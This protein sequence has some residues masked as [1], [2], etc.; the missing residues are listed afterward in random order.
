[1]NMTVPATT[2]DPVA[3]I[4]AIFQRARQQQLPLGE[5][6][7]TAERLAS[8]GA[9]APALDLYKTWIAFNDKNPL[10]HVASFN[11][12]VLL[13]QTGDTAGALQAL[14]ATI[15]YKA[16]FAPAHIN[17]GRVY[18][19]C[20][21]IG[22]AVQQ[23]RDFAST[24]NEITADRLSYRL[25]ALK[26]MGRVLESAGLLEEAEAV[27]WLAIE[28]DPSK[29]DAAQHWLAAR[30]HQCKWPIF[31]SSEH[32]TRRQLTDAM[33]PM[34]IAC[35]KDDPLFQLGKAY[36]YNKKLVGRPDTSGF[37][38]KPVRNKVE[39]GQ[40]IRIGYLSSDLREHAVGF[41]LCEVL[42]L[43]HKENVEVY[44]YYCGTPRTNDKT[45]DRI[46][47]V[48]DGWRDIN[49]MSDAEAAAKIVEDEIDIL[50]DVNGY[51]KQARAGVFAYKPAPV[52]VNFCGYPGTLASPHHQYI[53]TDDYIVPPE[54]ELYYTEKVLRIACEQPV[55]RK[56]E[57]APKPTRAEYGLPEDAFIYACFNG[58]QKIT[59]ECYL[60]WMKILAATPG[61]ILW[62]LGDKEPV[63]QRLRKIASENGVDPERLYFANKVPN[64]KHLARIAL[65]D[66]F[67]D[68]FPYGA[69]STAAD[70]ITMGLPVI[71][72]P[73]MGFPSRFCASIVAAAGI[74][75]M[76][77]SSPEEY[78]AKATALGRDKK[79]IEAVKATLAA[80]RETCTLRDMPGLARRLEE[81]FREMQEAAEQGKLPVPNL[82]NLEAYYEIGAELIHEMQDFHDEAAYRQLYREKLA[83][84][85]GQEPLLADPRLW[86]EGTA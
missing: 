2:V 83:L 37:I 1:M 85:D 27:L 78:V 50:I 73:G 39:A 59:E 61:S 62:L 42:E 9:Q 43:H 74:P 86:P 49:G 26:H 29:Q 67:L 75:E 21:M 28:L 81:L 16:D 3:V 31:V 80:K 71:T 56:R 14:R 33:S 72:V 35:F 18:E 40:R 57:I 58:M 84:R 17:L 55:D 41:A 8:L 20:Q 36:R 64:P 34:T 7:Q 12:A 23:W 19:D 76:I 66:L 60:R 54:R 11:Y 63:H 30:Q 10:I 4:Q 22:R 68:T 24:S 82:R 69:H 65:A 52:I 15:A 32:V 45:H 47:A 38:R 6:I 51:T 53:I 46:R 70:A 44:A 13:N 48:I 5:L 77:C 79:A 25:M